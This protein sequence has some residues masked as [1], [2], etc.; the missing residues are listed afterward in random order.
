MRAPTAFWSRG[1]TIPHQFHPRSRILTGGLRQI[2]EASLIWSGKFHAKLHVRAELRTVMA[3]V[4]LNFK[5]QPLGF[6]V[7]RKEWR[8]MSG[9]QMP[10]T[11]LV[12]AFLIIKNN[13]TT[14]LSS[15]FLNLKLDSGKIIHLPF[16]R[17]RERII[18]LN[19]LLVLGENRR[20]NA[21]QG[22]Y[23]RKHLGFHFV[24]LRIRFSGQ[25]SLCPSAAGLGYRSV[26]YSG[27]REK[28]RCLRQGC[29]I[30]KRGVP[31]RRSSFAL[32]PLMT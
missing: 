21:H 26:G 30:R 4:V 23:D 1:S 3:F 5:C 25:T 29:S 27:N 28:S 16:P 8:W 2:P 22:N 20:R 6:H 15:S 32:L 31:A 12:L 14:N 10:R 17:S 11:V 18:Q 19:C 9:Y 7:R 24:P 13:Y